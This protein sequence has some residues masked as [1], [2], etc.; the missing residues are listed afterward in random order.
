MSDAINAARAALLLIWPNGAECEHTHARTAFHALEAAEWLDAGNQE[1][2][3]QADARWHKG[4][5]NGGM[6]EIEAQAHMAKIRSMH[7]Q[8][9]H[10]AREDAR[11]QAAGPVAS[12][13]P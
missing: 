4:L 3:E 2:Q 9:M 12:A 7:Q 5:I 10:A 13:A 8:W 6:T 11:G 1:T